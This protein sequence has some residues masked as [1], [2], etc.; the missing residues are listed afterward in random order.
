MERRL[1]EGRLEKTKE[2]VNVTVT[3]RHKEGGQAGGK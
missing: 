3:E 2:I 1:Y